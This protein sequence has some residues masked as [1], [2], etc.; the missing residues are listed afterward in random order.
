MRGV[1][2]YRAG[3]ARRVEAGLRWGKDKAGSG[4]CSG[5][6]AIGQRRHWAEEAELWVVFSG[7]WPWA[8]HVRGFRSVRRARRK[9][10]RGGSVSRRRR[11]TSGACQISRR[12]GGTGLAEQ[13]RG[14][15]EGDLRSAG[16][17]LALRLLR[18]S[19][20]TGWAP[21][22]SSGRCR[23]GDRATASC[24][25]PAATRRAARERTCSG[26]RASRLPSGCKPDQLWSDPSSNLSTQHPKLP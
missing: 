22:L 10:Y 2:F 1:P 21:W 13:S 26:A 16:D 25:W 15:R 4:E 19:T 20:G 6:A 11:E 3:V 9:G 17:W 23:A 14:R 7:D 18:P 12:T 24:W 5:E 8:A